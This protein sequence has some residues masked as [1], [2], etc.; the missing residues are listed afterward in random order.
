MDIFDDIP[1]SVNPIVLGVLGTHNTITKQQMH[2]KILHPLMSVLGRVPE[3]IV[4]PSEGTSSAYVSIWAQRHNVNTHCVEADWKVF[5][6][7]AGILRDARITK[8]AT[9]FLVFVG[10]KSKTYERT[11]IRLAKKGNRVFVVDHD[12]IAMVEYIVEEA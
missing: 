7:K 12:P 9:H 2:E 5:Q 10:A 1:I 4:Y 11:A 6:R 3:L 8:E